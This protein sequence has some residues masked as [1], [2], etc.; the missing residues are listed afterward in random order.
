MRMN[1][2]SLF[3]SVDANRSGIALE[4]MNNS[5]GSGLGS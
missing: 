3:A 5:T 1:V 4:T 2:Y